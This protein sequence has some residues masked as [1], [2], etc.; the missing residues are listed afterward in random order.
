MQSPEVFLAVLRGSALRIAGFRGA[1][2]KPAATT[3]KRHATGIVETLVGEQ[4]FLRHRST[5]RLAAARAQFLAQILDLAR[6]AAAVVAAALPQFA[7]RLRD[8][9][10]PVVD[11]HIQYSRC[12]PGCCGVALLRN[13]LQSHGDPATVTLCGFGNRL[14]SPWKFIA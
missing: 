11:P 10:Q 1:A 2:R 12:P 14:A 8:R 9:I 5:H 6:P 7:A 4:E 3:G 13:A